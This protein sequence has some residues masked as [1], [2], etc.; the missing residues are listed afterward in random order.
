VKHKL[1]WQ[2][3]LDRAP[4]TPDLDRSP[5]ERLDVDGAAFAEDAWI[6]RRLR[7]GDTVVLALVTACRLRHG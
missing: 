1:V 4:A 3:H 2:R 5:D 7:I 6:G